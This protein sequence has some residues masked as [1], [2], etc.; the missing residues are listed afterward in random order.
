M[1]SDAQDH[2]QGGFNENTQ[3]KYTAKNP[4]CMQKKITANIIKFLHYI[5]S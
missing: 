1:L 4:Q 2:A 3:A 5:L